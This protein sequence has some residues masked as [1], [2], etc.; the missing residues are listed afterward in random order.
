MQSC[1]CLDRH[2]KRPL[3]PRYSGPHKVLQPHDTYFTL[4]MNERLP[5]VLIDRLKFAYLLSSTMKHEQRPSN[6][7]NMVDANNKN[8]VLADKNQLNSVTGSN[9]VNRNLN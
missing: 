8:I 9:S 6:S 4:T 2:I 3:N 5:N 7:A 1:F